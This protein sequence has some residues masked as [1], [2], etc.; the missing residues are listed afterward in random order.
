MAAIWCKEGLRI[1]AD[2]VFKTVATPE[3]KSVILFSN[4]ETI[5]NATVYGDLTVINSNGGEIFELVKGTWDASTD[6]D[7]VVSRYNGAT[8][9]VFNITGALTV[10]GWAVIG[11][12]NDVYCAENFGVKTFASGDTLTLQ[13]FDMKFDIV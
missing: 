4:D 7:P 9:V 13:P 1:L 3:V 5:T 8:G 10:Y 11:A 6:A 2:A 12:G